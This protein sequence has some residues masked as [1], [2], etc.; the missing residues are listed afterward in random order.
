[1]DI[2]ASLLSR[3]P[4]AQATAVDLKSWLVG[5]LMS[6]AVVERR[7]G[8][9]VVLKVQDQLVEAQSRQPL[10]VK[11]GDILTL[12]VIQNNNPAI[13]KIEPQQRPVTELQLQQQLLRETLPKQTG[14]EKL[15][16]VFQHARTEAKGTTE[17]LPLPVR[18]QL[19]KIIDSLPTSRSLES[20]GGLKTALQDSGLFLEAKMLNNARAQTPALSQWQALL[21]GNDLKA[22]LLQLFR[23]IE[24]TRPKF[25][26]ASTLASTKP[27]SSTPVTTAT[28][29]SFDSSQPQMVTGT[30]TNSYTAATNTAVKTGLPLIASEKQMDMENIGKQV[31]SALARIETN[32]ARSIVTDTQPLSTW[33]FELPVKDDN[34]LDLVKLELEQEQNSDD[35]EQPGKTWTVNLDVEF[36][37]GGSL[38]AR[39]SMYGTEMHISLW[40][41]DQE[42]DSL[43]QDHLQK[44]NDNLQN[45][46]VSLQALQ[47][48]QQAQLQSKPD[49]PETRLIS[50]KL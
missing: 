37:N 31:E 8:N 44:L 21:P 23:A 35:N 6:A 7:P 30:K 27:S 32:Q 12:R 49:I 33:R 50:V 46:G 13:L 4:A 22:G 36:E 42:I 38:S 26:S 17:L 1:M 18:K 16:T 47:H 20:T 5:K 24:K 29:S 48:V 9:A 25:P 39:A 15:N 34:D 10:N 3:V 2:Q 14:I 41:G 45:K 43:I 28:T 11:T 19:Q 40:S